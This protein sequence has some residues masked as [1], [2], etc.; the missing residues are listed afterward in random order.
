METYRH[1]YTVRA[2][3][4]DKG[5]R[6][7]YVIRSSLSSTGYIFQDQDKAVSIKLG[8]WIVRDS[9]TNKYSVLSDKSFKRL[10][11]K[12]LR[13]HLSKC[14]CRTFIGFN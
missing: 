3:R 8:D 9:A 7:P 12:K 4:F 6:H 11:V 13:R 5:S 10:Y 14:E 2:K 1:R